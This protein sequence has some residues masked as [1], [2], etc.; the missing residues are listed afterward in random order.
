MT[1]APKKEKVGGTGNDAEMAETLWNF[2]E[3]AIKE[4][5]VI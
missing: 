3:K 1:G 5:F 2:S 4:K